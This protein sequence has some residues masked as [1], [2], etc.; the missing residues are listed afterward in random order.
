MNLQRMRELAGDPPVH[1]HRAPG[2]QGGWGFSREYNSGT[3]G[4]GNEGSEPR[5]PRYLEKE[6]KIRKGRW[7]RM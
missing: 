7:L 2:K 6:I 3:R 5:I 4:E 1:G